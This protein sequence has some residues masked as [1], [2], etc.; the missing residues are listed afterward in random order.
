[1]AGLILKLKPNEEFLINGAVVQ[2]GERKTRLRVK[3]DGAA[4]LRLRDAM[5]PQDA[6]TSERRAYYVAQ[7]AVAGEIQPADAAAI[8]NQALAVLASKYAGRREIDA[9]ARAAEELAAGRFYSVMRRLADV[10]RPVADE[11]VGK[12]DGS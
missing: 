3:T 6:T 4:V 10:A 7:L 2:N 12:A 9:I 1:M 5:R 11:C 8:L